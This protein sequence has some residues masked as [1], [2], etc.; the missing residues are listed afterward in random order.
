M[1]VK[2]SDHHNIHDN[3]HAEN[4]DNND[5]RWCCIIVISWDD[6]QSAPH[7]APSAVCKKNG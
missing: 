3:K 1:H 5:T 4:D 7:N 2:G 6:Q